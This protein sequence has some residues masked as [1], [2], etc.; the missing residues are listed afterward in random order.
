MSVLFG[1]WLAQLNRPRGNP[2]TIPTTCGEGYSPRDDKYTRITDGGESIALLFRWVGAG[3][4]TLLR[5]VAASSAKRS[6]RLD[7]GGKM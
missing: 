2:N 7:F 6:A 3:M 1:P 4:G 5:S